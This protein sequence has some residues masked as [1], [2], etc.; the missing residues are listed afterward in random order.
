MFCCFSW[1][2]KFVSFIMFLFVMIKWSFQVFS[3]LSPWIFLKANLFDNFRANQRR[4]WWGWE[5]SVLLLPWQLW[6]CWCL[7]YRVELRVERRE[8]LLL[9][10]LHLVVRLYESKTRIVSRRLGRGCLLDGATDRAVGACVVPAALSAQTRAL[11]LFW[12]LR[13]CWGCRH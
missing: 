6:G 7:R 13:G 4:W 10:L 11:F 1:T 5:V 3:L 2:E 8:L 12:R 9:F